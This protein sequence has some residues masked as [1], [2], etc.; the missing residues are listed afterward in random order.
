GFSKVERRD[1]DGSVCRTWFGREGKS[2]GRPIKLEIR[3]PD[4]G[5]SLKEWTWGAPGSDSVYGVAL[6]GERQGARHHFY[7]DHDAHGQPRAEL[8]VGLDEAIL[9][10]S[11]YAGRE[12]PQL[13]LVD[14]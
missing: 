10:L 2:A 9:T 3:Q 1:S 5:L 8:E 6:T 13:Y 4:G 11:Q 7:W 12:E 14:R